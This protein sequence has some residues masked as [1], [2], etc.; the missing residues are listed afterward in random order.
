MNYCVHPGGC[1]NFWNSDSPLSDPLAWSV[2]VSYNHHFIYL[3][4]VIMTSMCRSPYV[5]CILGTVGT[6]GVGLYS[7]IHNDPSSSNNNISKTLKIQIQLPNPVFATICWKNFIVLQYKRII[8]VRSRAGGSSLCLIHYT[9]LWFWRG[10]GVDA[11]TTELHFT[12]RRSTGTWYQVH[13]GWRITYLET[14]ACSHIM[15]LYHCT[16]L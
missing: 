10:D 13:K 14:S 12:V 15:V 9:P 8:Y 3:S 1:L 6:G 16:H 11:I 2:S 4:N 7:R 5:H